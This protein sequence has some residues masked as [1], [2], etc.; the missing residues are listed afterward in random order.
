MANVGQVV[1]APALTRR[2]ID[3]YVRERLGRGARAAGAFMRDRLRQVVGVQAPRKRA[4]SGWVATVRAS[5]GL[6][7]RRVS[8]AGQK[9]VGYR[10]TESNVI[11]SAIFYM[12][13]HERRGHPWLAKTLEKH[14]EDFV[15][16]MRG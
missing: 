2:Q 9:S 5:P 7:P 13:A 16:I 1:G 10:V 14:R 11:F 3:E 6:P 8:G 4:G 12:L 15:R